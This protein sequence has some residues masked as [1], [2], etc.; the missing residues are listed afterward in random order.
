MRNLQSVKSCAESL[1]GKNRDN[2]TPEFE[3]SRRSTH[4]HDACRETQVRNLQFAEIYNARAAQQIDHS[5]YLLSTVLMKS[6]ADMQR[7]D[8][9]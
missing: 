4:C 1:I 2:L 5:A 8:D 3:D 9:T 6:E 7:N